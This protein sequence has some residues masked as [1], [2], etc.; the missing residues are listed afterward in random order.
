MSKYF[1]EVLFR[2]NN[3]PYLYMI[4]DNVHF[5]SNKYYM[6]ETA[7]G[8]KYTTPVCLFSR[9]KSNPKKDILCKTIIKATLVESPKSSKI[10]SFKKVVYNDTARTTTIWWN[11]YDF[12]TVKAIEGDAYSR[13]A[14]FA[15]CVL[16]RQLGNREFADTMNAY[17]GNNQNY[18][19]SKKMEKERAERKEAIKQKENEPKSTT[20]KTIRDVQ[21]FLRGE[22]DMNYLEH[23]AL[24][25]AKWELTY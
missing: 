18:Y 2:G 15:L 3:K 6:I 7:E 17:C 24:D 9:S 23:I 14:G 16:K 11:D 13:E 8:D 12:T 20:T 1:V 5:E 22:N 21:G 10:V 4:N 19:F 25:R